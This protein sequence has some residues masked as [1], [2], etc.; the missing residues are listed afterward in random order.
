MMHRRVRGRSL[1]FAVR[2][3]LVVWALLLVGVSARVAFSKPASQTV[4][5]IY[6]NGSQRW[7]DGDDLYASQ[8][9]LDLYRNPPGFAAAFVPFTLLSEKVAGIVWRILSAAVFLAA[10]AQWSRRGLPRPLT[11]SE[12]GCLFLLAAPLALPSLNNGQ[13]NLIV[14]GMLLF[15]ATAAADARWRS[16][17]L[18]LAAAAAVKVYPLAVGLLIGLAARRRCFP[19]LGIGC[20]A[21]IAF[22]FLCREPSYVLDMYRS[23][24][25]S[26]GAD[27]R[28]FAEPSRAPKDL[29]LVLRVW[30]VAPPPQLYLAGKLALSGGMAALVWFTARRDPC[31]AVPLALHL[32]CLWIT[33]FGPATEVHTYTLLAPT[34]AALLLFAFVERRDEGG[35]IRLVMIA[36]GYLLVISPVLRDMFPNGAAFQGLGPQPVGGLLLLVAL[37]WTALLRH[38]DQR[39]AAKAANFSI[40]PP[41]MGLRRNPHVR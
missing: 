37:T 24:A 1:P 17:G 16:A 30:F 6:L 15:G 32:G 13:A 39:K 28:T 36:L 9:P 14:A 31:R 8:P 10:L 27:D 40:I 26:T 22:P 7:V 21:A 38:S 23:L 4:V 3:A 18:W 2:A 33:V 41:A 12:T 25:Q 5:P 20:A 34:A 11:A 19:W 29:F 35:M